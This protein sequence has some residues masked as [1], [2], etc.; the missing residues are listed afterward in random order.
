MRNKKKLLLEAAASFAI[1]FATAFSRAG[2]QSP[3]ESA[4]QMGVRSGYAPINGVKMYYEVRGRLTNEQTPLVL[5]HGGG[6][7]IQTSFGSV[8]DELAKNRPVIAFEQRGH[9]H[10]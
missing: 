3:A 5:L 6:S 10:S 4:P 2:A 7:T 9:G 8:I 1:V